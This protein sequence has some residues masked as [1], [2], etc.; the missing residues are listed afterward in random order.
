MA[1]L[2]V[3]FDPGGKGQFGW[4]VLERRARKVP[5]LIATG[6]ADHAGAAVNEVKDIAGRKSVAA[7]AID[8]PLYWTF[9]ASREA[10]RLIRSAIRARGAL[11]PGGTVQQVNSLRGA[12]LSQGILAAHLLRQKWPEIRLT[13]SHPK[14]LLWLLGIATVRRRPPAIRVRHLDA[15]VKCGDNVA[16]EHRRDAILGAIAADQMLMASPDWV[17]LVDREEVSAVFTPIRDIEYWMPL[18]PFAG[19]PH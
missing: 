13:E 9:A 18:R 15:L 16:C 5:R 1:N 7:A 2:I 3:G 8:S 10:D 17:N 19:S 14:A 6:L 4:C 11:S 12:C